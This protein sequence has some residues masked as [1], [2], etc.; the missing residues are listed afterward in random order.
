MRE[1]VVVVVVSS[2][3]VS[4][5]TLVQ[6]EL[7]VTLLSMLDSSSTNKLSRSDMMRSLP[8]AGPSQGAARA[9]RLAN[10]G[11]EAH[12]V[13]STVFVVQCWGLTLTYN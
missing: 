12:L 10:T 2:H 6:V 5:V 11:G 7:L 13:T 3:P 1:V 8:G 4:T 9:E